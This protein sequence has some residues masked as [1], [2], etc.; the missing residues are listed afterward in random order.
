MDLRIKSWEDVCLVYHAQ[1]KNQ[2][3]IILNAVINIRVHKK[4]GY[5]LARTVSCQL[6]KKDFVTWS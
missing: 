5:F 3:R 1:D 2:W 4:A 6:L